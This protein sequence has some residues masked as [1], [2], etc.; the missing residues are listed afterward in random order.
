MDRDKKSELDAALAGILGGL[1]ALTAGLLCTA[2]FS[3]EDDTLGLDFA[4][5]PE[6]EDGAVYK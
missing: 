2:R 6:V 5:V 4:S 1:V 3:R